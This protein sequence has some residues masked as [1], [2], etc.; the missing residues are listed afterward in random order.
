MPALVAPTVG[1]L[2]R[3]L[4]EFLRQNPDEVVNF[5]DVDR[6]G[7]M[8]SPQLVGEHEVGELPPDLKALYFL[9]KKFADDIVE[10]NEKY[11]E[12]VEVGD[13]GEAADALVSMTCDKER[14]DAVFGL[15][16]V[17]VKDYFNLWDKEIINIRRGFKVVWTTEDE[18]FAATIPDT[19]FGRGSRVDS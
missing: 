8:L 13:G 18:V 7:R 15:F 6:Y 3:T 17:S 16:A 11:A 19:T 9:A 12:A 10:A 5:E 4:Y 1:D 2:I 14:Y